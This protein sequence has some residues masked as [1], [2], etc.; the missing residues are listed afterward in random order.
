M[1][2]ATKE[3]RNELWTR[4]AQSVKFKQGVS[5]ETWQTEANGT[6]NHNMA[7]TVN[8]KLICGYDLIRR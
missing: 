4:F 5:A 1:S 7:Q 8:I 2:A 6:A 3:K